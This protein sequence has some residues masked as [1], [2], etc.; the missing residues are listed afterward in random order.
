[1][2]EG[3]PEVTARAEKNHRIAM[4]D[5][6]AELMT[7]AISIA[8]VDAFKI[9]GGGDFFSRE[10]I[11]AWVRIVE[12][13][14]RV[15][16]Y[17]YSRAWVRPD[18]MPAL[19]SLAALPNMRLL[20]SHDATMPT[21]PAIPHAETAWL[22]IH[23]DDVPP[24]RGRVCFRASKERKRIPLKVIGSTVVCPQQ[25]GQ[26]RTIYCIDCGICLP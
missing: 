24:Q 13:L 25:N 4:R 5:D 19:T 22:A 16:F 6:F 14:P 8:D 3:R 26:S 20:L 12:R 15:K 2:N 7:G 1:M 10:Y 9:H 11:D 17:A 23:D 18:F 21:P